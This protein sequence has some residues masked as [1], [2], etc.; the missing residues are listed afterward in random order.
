MIVTHLP[1]QDGMNTMHITVLTPSVFPLCQ[2]AGE[3]VFLSKE[4]AKLPFIGPRLNIH[5]L[6][7]TRLIQDRWVMPVA[8][9]GVD[10]HLQLLE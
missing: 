7:T 8:R 1:I 5:H 6:H 2:V 9:F 3:W 10:M 4:L